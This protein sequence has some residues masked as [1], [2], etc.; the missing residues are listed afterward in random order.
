[1]K[2]AHND[3]RERVPLGSARVSRVR[4]RVLAIANFFLARPND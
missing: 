3:S 2:N 4:E 1:L